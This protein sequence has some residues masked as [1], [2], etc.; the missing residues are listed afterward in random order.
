MSNNTN[1][2]GTSFW[3]F[4]TD[5][6]IE[7]PIIQRDYAQGR[8]G[9]EYLRKSFLVDIKKALDNKTEMKLDFV[10]GS[11]ENDTLSPL[12]GQQRLTTLWLLHWYIAL[13]SGNL[14]EEVCKRLAK[15]TYETRI[16]SREFCKNLCKP[17]NFNDYQEYISTEEDR[18]I[19]EYITSR[20]WFYSAWKQDPTIQSMLRMLGGTVINDKKG[21]IV[22]GLEELF[23]ETT[24]FVKYWE[25]LISDDAPIVFYQ[26]PLKDFGLSDDLYIKMNA[27]GKQ[28]TSF[29]NFKADLVGYIREK[30]Q[31]NPQEWNN[32]LDAKEGI[33]N[34]MDTTWTDIFWKNKSQDNRIDDIYFAFLNRFFLCELICQKVDD[35]YRERIA[36]TSSFRYLYGKEGNDASIKYE[37]FG[38]YKYDNKE[39]PKTFFESLKAVLDNYTENPN[40][41][42][43]KWVETEFQFIPQYRN[44]TIS[45]LGQKE[46]V[47][48]LAVCRYLEKGKIDDSF[49]QWMRIV[50]NIVE[51][52]DAGMIGAMR[53][54][55]ELGEHS[56]EIYKFMANEDTKI[57]SEAAK[58]QV[59]EEIAKVKQIL[60]NRKYTNEGFA[61]NVITHAE[62]HPLLKGCIS[63]LFDSDNC[64]KVSFSQSLYDR[65]NLLNE[66]WNKDNSE[67]YRLVK[68]LI[69]LYDKDMPEDKLYLKKNQEN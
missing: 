67:D 61:E 30:T 3:K 69:S 51:N 4:L 19:V 15:F 16:S 9:K 22:D 38:K 8:L 52:N 6:T 12:D 40:L 37:D 25:K 42:F 18:K 66:L 48:F 1:T 49:K 39:I 59:N 2:Q 23:N 20:T 62:S 63:A 43:P 27:R 45:T 58:E 68:V 14:N 24:N 57:K 55:D 7:I 47:V 60:M 28:L 29:E 10:Y 46:R 31:D 65:V 26:L 41:F 64:E 11:V 5:N 56:H 21:D 34:K 53:L 33:P 36:E 32:L 35:K 50:W 44:N 17:K 13:M 54:I